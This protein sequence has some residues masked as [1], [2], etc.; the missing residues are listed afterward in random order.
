M[1]EKANFMKNHGDAIAI[2]ASVVGV[3]IALAAILVALYMSN[4]SGIANCMTRI[5][6]CMVRIDGIYELLMNNA[7]LTLPKNKIPFNHSRGFQP[8]NDVVPQPNDW[9]IQDTKQGE[10]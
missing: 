9:M 7:G 6:S 4:A 3:N 5:D 8:Y 1:S 10:K 2:I